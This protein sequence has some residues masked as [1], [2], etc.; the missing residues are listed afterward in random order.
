MTEESAL[1]T[2]WHSSLE[3]NTFWWA[4]TH[5]PMLTSF[6][7]DTA[8]KR[9]LL[10]VPVTSYWHPNSPG[11]SSQWF[12]DPFLHSQFPVCLQHLYLLLGN[13]KAL[14]HLHFSSSFQ[15]HLS[16]ITVKHKERQVLPFLPQGWIAMEMALPGWGGLPKHIAAWYSCP[17]D[18][19]QLPHHWARW[20]L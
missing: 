4:F 10:T 14:W 13:H 18:M 3:T 17:H 5:C 2:R 20:H 19:L 12:P 11:K 1:K 15:R 16:S 8:V 6:A 9:R 7:M